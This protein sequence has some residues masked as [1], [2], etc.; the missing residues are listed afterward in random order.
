M[1]GTT[2]IWKNASE[3]LDKKNKKK[4]N[5]TQA[6]TQDGKIEFVSFTSSFALGMEKMV[7]GNSDR[8]TQ[9]RGP[10]IIDFNEYPDAKDHRTYLQIDG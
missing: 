2:D 3:V 9:G 1:G 7:S 6:S 4:Q 5:H 10:F 8:I